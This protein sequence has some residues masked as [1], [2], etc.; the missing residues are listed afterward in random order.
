[1]YPVAPRTSARGAVPSGRGCAVTAGSRPVGAETS[2][3]LGRLRERA[4]LPYEVT[5]GHTE[6]GAVPGPVPAQRRLAKTWVPSGDGSG[7]NP[8]RG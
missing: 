7:S 4:D 3:T 8:T 5:C 6:D 1:M 2:S